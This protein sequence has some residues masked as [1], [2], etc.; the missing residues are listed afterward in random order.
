M[1]WDEVQV[2]RGQAYLDE[3]IGSLKA[4]R[5]A[6]GE[7]KLRLGLV[8][9]PQA[10]PARLAL[11]EFYFYAQRNSQAMKVLEEGF[12]AVPDY[13][14]RRYMT[15]YF[16]IALQGDDY[17]SVLDVCE[18]Y[19]T[20]QKAGVSEKE[21]DWLFQQKLNALIKNG[22][23]ELALQL[24]EKNPDNL[25]LNEQRVLVMIELG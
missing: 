10:M 11:A 7:M 16:T 21:S 14:G 8:R 12:D 23:A 13:P 20:G 24:L 5:W 25:I 22:A 18:R 15:N 6:E 2:K 19:L 1:R 4:Q 3:G 9:Y 17:G